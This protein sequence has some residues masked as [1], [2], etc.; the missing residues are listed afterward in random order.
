MKLVKT[1]TSPDLETRIKEA[2]AE[3][4]RQGLREWVVPQRKNKQT[5]ITRK[6]R[7]DSKQI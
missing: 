4:S 5:S 3:A 6:E 7:N 2:L 1:Q